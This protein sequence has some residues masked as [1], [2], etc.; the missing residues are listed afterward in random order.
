MSLQELQ[1]QVKPITLPDML[2]LHAKGQQDAADKEKIVFEMVF[3][4]R[5]LP[6]LTS[7]IAKKG[8]MPVFG[9][10]LECVYAFDT[11]RGIKGSDFSYNRKELFLG[12]AWYVGERL[13]AV[14]PDYD[15]SSELRIRPGC[16]QNLYMLEIVLTRKDP[17]RPAEAQQQGS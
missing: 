11:T 4:Q 16:L 9:C 12:W 8:V 5:V 10:D 2:A 1:N 6:L 3:Q 13:K 17:P 14:F 15:V 7:V